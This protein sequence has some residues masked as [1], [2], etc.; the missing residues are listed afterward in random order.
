MS[1][2]MMFANSLASVISRQ[3]LFDMPLWFSE[4]YAEYSSRHGWD[5]FADMY[6]RDQTINDNLIPPYY[7]YGYPAYKQGQAMVKFIADKYGEEKL[8]EIIRKGRIHLTMNRTLESVL[9]ID[10]EKFYEEFTKEMKRRYWPPSTSARRPM[11]SAGG[12]PRPARTAR[13]STKSPSI[14]P[15]ATS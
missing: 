13:T 10:E 9:G 4:G 3:R 6:V 15:R 2:E 7:L 12:S 5:Y 11:K 8:G 1:Y 14:R